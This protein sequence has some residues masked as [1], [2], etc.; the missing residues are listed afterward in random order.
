[1]GNRDAGHRIQRVRRVLDPAVFPFFLLSC[2]VSRPWR[3]ARDRVDPEAAW[4]LAAGHRMRTH[5]ERSGAGKHPNGIPEDMPRIMPEANVAQGIVRGA[6]LGP[7][8]ATE[9]NQ[10]PDR[11]RDKNRLGN[12]RKGRDWGAGDGLTL[13]GAC[14]GP[15]KRRA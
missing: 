3:R 2:L 9:Y 8:N 11:N 13:S 5:R 10:T 14:G 4:K 1:M 15:R 6:A 12:S 7:T